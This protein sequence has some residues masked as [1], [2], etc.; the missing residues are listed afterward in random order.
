MGHRYQPYTDAEREEK[1]WARVDK[2]PGQGP[3]GDCWLW[4][5]SRSGGCL[6]KA[7]RYVWELVH[8]EPAPPDGEICHHC[9]NPPC[10]NPQHLFK[11]T[12][13]DNM[14]DR[15]A[16]GSARDS[17]P[18]GPHQ[19]RRARLP[20]PGAS[21]ERRSPPLVDPRVGGADVGLRHLEAVVEPALGTGAR[22]GC[23]GSPDPDPPG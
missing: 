17:P 6:I 22:P 5:G 15:D 7:H 21:R 20:A 3:K 13:L 8:G 1:F 16:K 18:A 19:K 9:D 2:T 12:H 14:R 11:G 4:I 10:V 23:A